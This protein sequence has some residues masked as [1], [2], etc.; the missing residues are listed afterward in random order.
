MNVQ[1]VLNKVEKLPPAPAVLPMLLKLLSNTD[2]DPSEIVGYI[3]VDQSLMAQVLKLANS[4][5][6]GGSH[7][8]DLDDA[9]GRIGYH[10]VY[11]LVGMVCGK[12]MLG[13]KITDLCIED[14][15]LWEYSLASGYVMEL[16]AQK[17]DIDPSTSYTI[18]ILHSLGKVVLSSY[19][20]FHY[21]RVIDLIE[22]RGLTLAQAERAIY[23]VT[24]AQ[25]ASAL[26]KKWKFDESVTVPIEY[27]SNPLSAAEEHRRTTC[28]LNLAIWTVSSLGHNHGK[29]SWAFEVSDETVESIG[30]SQ[31]ELQRF[32][33][34]AH[35]KLE[36]IKE[37]LDQ[38]QTV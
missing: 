26:L 36:E 9:V 30:L 23:G 32:I 35:D 12:E 21:N 33:V 8:Y 20:E 7:V 29:D 1:T 38:K 2:S 16:L 14:G 4:A 18:G 3:K 13:S 31:K 22:K 11:K 6:F 37:L 27:Q 34:T 5:F 10:E 19:K 17:V 28:M 24:N 25:V 15:Q